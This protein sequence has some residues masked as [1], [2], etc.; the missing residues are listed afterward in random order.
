MSNESGGKPSLG[1]LF[2]SNLII[3]TCTF[4]GGFVIAG[5]MKKDYVDKHHWLDEAEMMDYIAIAQSC[6]GPIAVNTAILSGYHLRGFAGIAVSVAAM[7]LPPM[8]ILSLISLFYSAFASSRLFAL[9]LKG[10]QAGVAAVIL[11]VV[12]S[13][14]IKT[15]KSGVMDI[16]VMV[17][18]FAACWFLKANATWIILAV[19]LLGIL[20]VVFR[21]VRGKAVD[22]Q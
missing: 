10:M 1:R 12:L 6:P 21:T 16:I 18:A 17:L 5:L 4:G 13:L 19:L 3:S 15:A 8:V 11:D 2:I 20:R 9:L 22:K 7:I 14:G